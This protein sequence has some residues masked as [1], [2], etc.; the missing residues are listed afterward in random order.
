[1]RFRVIRTLQKFAVVHAEPYKLFM[2][3]RHLT[4]RPAYNQ[5]PSAAL[6]E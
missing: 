1:M 3:D 2:L 6:A 4:N 5:K